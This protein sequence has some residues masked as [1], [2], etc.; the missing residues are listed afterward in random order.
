MQF[1]GH[2]P[3]LNTE[4]YLLGGLGIQH[5]DGNYIAVN[6][7][8][9]APSLSE[10]LNEFKGAVNFGLGAEKHF[11]DFGIFG[12]F[13]L[14][15]GQKSTL[16]TG[17]LIDALYSFGVKYDLTVKKKIKNKEVERYGHKRLTRKELKGNKPKANGGGKLPGSKYDL[18]L[19]QK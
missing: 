3:E 19:I 10:H 11:D 13:K 7:Q 9:G 5:W 12:E 8:Y 6:D 16:S 4:L 15:V 14:R 18:D 1:M 17:D 2:L